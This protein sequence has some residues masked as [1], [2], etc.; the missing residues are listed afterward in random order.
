MDGKDPVSTFRS[1]VKERY[2]GPLKGPFNA[3]DRKKAGMTREYYEEL[4]GDFGRDETA[5]PGVAV[6]YEV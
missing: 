2:S 5:K 1:L 6:A 3:D 4:E